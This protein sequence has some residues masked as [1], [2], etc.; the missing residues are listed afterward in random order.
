MPATRAWFL[1]K[2]PTTTLGMNIVIIKANRFLILINTEALG[3]YSLFWIVFNTSVFGKITFNLAV[4]IDI[5]S[6]IL[7]E[8]IGVVVTWGLTVNLGWCGAEEFNC[9]VGVMKLGS[10]G[11]GITDA[12][13]KTIV[14]LIMLSLQR[15]IFF[16]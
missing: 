13:P 5:S 16:I 8:S 9:S 4:R 3:F 14:N 6:V 15:Y 7:M 1:A 10:I 12:G 2:C 11:I